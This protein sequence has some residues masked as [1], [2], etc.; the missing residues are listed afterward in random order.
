MPLRISMMAWSM[1][2]KSCSTISLFLPSICSRKSTIGKKRRTVSFM[3]NSFA[4]EIEKNSKAFITIFSHGNTALII[5]YIRR[6][7]A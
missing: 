3:G 6:Y 7:I 2:E 4:I 5:P 1:S